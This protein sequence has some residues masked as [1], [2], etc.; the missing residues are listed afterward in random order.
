MKT[1]EEIDIFHV[2]EIGINIRDK[3]HRRLKE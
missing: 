1:S 3:L 2:L